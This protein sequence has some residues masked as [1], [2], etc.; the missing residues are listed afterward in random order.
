MDLRRVRVW[1]WLTGLAGAVLLISLFLPWYGAGDATATAW[2]AFAITDV[3]LAL[4]ALMAI[5]LPIVA[6]TQRTVAVPQSWTALIMLIVVPGILIALFR[7]L[8]L[9]GDGLGREIGVWLGF[10]A[11]LAVFAC[12]YR[13]MG[14]STF[15]RAMRPRL[16]IETIPTPSPDG[17]R[18]DVTQ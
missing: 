12:D 18:R 1:E 4:V 11:T 14:D 7:L 10:A 16:D 6:A 2:E 17:Q 5:A 13:S 15:P 8:N 9:P 3:V